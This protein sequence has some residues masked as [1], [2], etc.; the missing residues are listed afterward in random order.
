M[1]TKSKKYITTRVSEQI[2]AHIWN[3]ALSCD[4]DED[5]L[6]EHNYFCDCYKNGVYLKF[7]K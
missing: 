6:N 3:N 5:L 4:T 7:I 2:W 1:K